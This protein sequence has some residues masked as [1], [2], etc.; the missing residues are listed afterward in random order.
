METMIKHIVFEFHGD[1]AS[2][3]RF[4]FPPYAALDLR[5]GGVEMTASFFVERAG[6]ALLNN[7]NANTSLTP[8]ELAALRA[9]YDVNTEYYQPVT[10]VVRANQ[11][12]TIENI[13]RAARTLPEVQEHM[14]K[15]MAE[16]S[17]A[18][19]EFLVL[20]LPREKGVA[21]PSAATAAAAAGNLE[22]D[23]GVEMGSGDEDDE[24]K[25]YYGVE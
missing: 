1:G 22:V 11:H 17:R 2:T 5:F 10:I 15:V 13:A 21:V 6:S 12:K 20:Q 24:L 3:D 9:S 8:E 4:L 25:T 19:S 7:L 23:S 14:K 16:K 18:P